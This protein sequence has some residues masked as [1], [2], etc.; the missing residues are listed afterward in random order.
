MV[1]YRKINIDYF[2]FFLLSEEGFRDGV[3]GWDRSMEFCRLESG[4]FFSEIVSEEGD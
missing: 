3:I 1:G 4:F 2:C